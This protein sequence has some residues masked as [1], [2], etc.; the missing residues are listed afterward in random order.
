MDSGTEKTHIEYEMPSNAESEDVFE[1]QKRYKG[2][3]IQPKF[4][5]FPTTKAGMS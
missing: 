3:Q 5:L 2:K 4:P 1:R